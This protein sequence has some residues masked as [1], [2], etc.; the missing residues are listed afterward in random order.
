MGSDKRS[1]IIWSSVIA[2]GITWSL[3]PQLFLDPAFWYVGLIW[4]GAYIAG[5]IREM[6]TTGHCYASADPTA[7]GYALG[8]SIPLMLWLGATGHL[9]AW[10]MWWDLLRAFPASFAAGHLAAIA[11]GALLS[12]VAPS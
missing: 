2:Y 10:S 11:S 1:P 7:L 8:A 4:G 6:I 9:G 5:Q 3:V 12:F